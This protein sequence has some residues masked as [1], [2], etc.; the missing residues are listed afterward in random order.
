MVIIININQ[1]KKTYRGNNLAISSSPTMFWSGSPIDKMTL[2]ER[3]KTNMTHTKM[4]EMN[5][6]SSPTSVV[7]DWWSLSG[8]HTARMRLSCQLCGVLFFISASML[9]G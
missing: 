7:E 6:F 8:G 1:Y 9:T 3:T 4:I 5:V 2:S